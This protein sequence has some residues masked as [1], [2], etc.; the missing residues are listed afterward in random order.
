MIWITKFPKAVTCK[1]PGNL[2]FQHRR[3]IICQRMHSSY[4]SKCI[5]T[6]NDDTQNPTRDYCWEMWLLVH[7]LQLLRDLRDFIETSRPDHMWLLQYLDR[8][9]EFNDAAQ[10][11]LQEHSNLLVDFRKQPQYRNLFKNFTADFVDTQYNC[12]CTENYR[13]SDRTN[14]KTIKCVDGENGF[15]TWNPAERFPECITGVF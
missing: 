13:Y 12:N 7:R 9:T 6:L 8:M 14:S 10:F 2:R 15:G 5:H 11:L 4:E 3:N 1:E